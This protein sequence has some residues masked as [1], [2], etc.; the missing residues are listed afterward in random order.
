[1]CNKKAEGKEVTE[2]LIVGIVLLMLG[3]GL[4]FVK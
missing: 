3:L 4:F 2:L 1:M